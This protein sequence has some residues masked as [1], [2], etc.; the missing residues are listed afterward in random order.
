MTTLT[1]YVYDTVVQAFAGLGDLEQYDD[2][3]LTV[4]ARLTDPDASAL[5][6]VSRY[7]GLLIIDGAAA[8]AANGDITVTD[9]SAGDLTVRIAS[10]E[11]ESLAGYV[12]M[13][14]RYTLKGITIAGVGLLN[15]HDTILQSGLVELANS[16]TRKRD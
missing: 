7:A 14:A 16:A 1:W 15:E 9:V 13:T 5:A 11:T 10:A 2:I 3:V 12:G 6:Q 4:K 8:T